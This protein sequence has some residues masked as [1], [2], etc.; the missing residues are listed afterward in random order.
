MQYFSF[1]L[2]VKV[3]KVKSKRR[4]SVVD[5]LRF[6]ACLF[7]IWYHSPYI[8]YEDNFYAFHFTGSFLFVELFFML[9]GYFTIKHFADKRYEEVSF[10][11]KCKNAVQYTWNKFKEFLPYTILAVLLTYLVKMIYLD[12][13]SIQEL[14]G[15]LKKIVLELLLLN[16]QGGGMLGLTWYLAAILVIYPIFCTLCQSK[17]KQFIFFL[18]VPFCL[19]YYLGFST[20]ASTDP[21][22]IIRSAAGMSMGVIV[23]VLSNF[24]GKFNFKNIWILVLSLI[25]LLSFAISMGLLYTND[26][27]IVTT[28]RFYSFDIIFFFF[29]TLSLLLSGKTLQSKIHF[30]LFDF[31]GKISLQFY[32]FHLLV[33]EIIYLFLND[34]LSPR[35]KMIFLY[36]GTFIVSICVY[37]IVELAKIKMPPV[38]KIFLKD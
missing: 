26:R 36:A 16:T 38:R 3:E 13:N 27:L 19:T 23:Y 31:L 21:T 20:F 29:L 4:I 8:R 22:T 32:L 34:Y 11:D 17:Y 10:N 14:I 6:I 25:E 5:L 33:H 30:W 7:I 18:I 2:E 12:F 9:T 1:L 24:I 37:A 15:F 28:D 35:T